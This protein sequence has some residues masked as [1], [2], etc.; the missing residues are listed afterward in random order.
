M[1]SDRPLTVLLTRSDEPLER[2][3][4]S[5][6]ASV[7]TVPC[8]RRE[9]A[10]R[11]LLVEALAGLDTDD[12]LVLTSRAGVDAIAAVT[13]A[14][15][16]PCAIAVVGPATAAQLRRLG[17]EPEVIPSAANG[18]SLAAELPLPKGVVLLARSDRALDDL[19]ETLHA[20][21][22]RV[23]EVVAY[24]SRP[25][26]DGDVAAAREALAEGATVVFASPTAVEGFVSDVCAE[27][28]ADCSVVAIGPTTARAVT[29][30]LGLVP[31]AATR[32]T[33]DAVAQLV[34]EGSHVAHR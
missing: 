18:A 25:G 32:P 10:D 30:L 7:V 16:V 9:P 23:R 20:R 14:R 26:A 27:L 17:R 19:P 33:A 12:L 5:R 13:D 24:R 21:G 31:L 6:G 34:L 4:S 2:E 3:L 11:A 29:R 22:A 8:V 15:A 1:R 28:P